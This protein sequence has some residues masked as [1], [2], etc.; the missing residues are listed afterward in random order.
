MND[1]FNKENES[2]SFEYYTIQ[3][4]DTLP[5]IANN[6]GVS[7]DDIMKYNS[8]IESNNK[9]IAGQTIKIPQSEKSKTR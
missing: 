1:A 3:K 8:S 4:G 5:E 2:I 9:I 7:C 6:Y